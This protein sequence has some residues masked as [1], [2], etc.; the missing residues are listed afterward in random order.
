MID[1][2]RSARQRIYGLLFG[3][4]RASAK[5]YNKKPLGIKIDSERQVTIQEY[6]VDG[7]KRSLLE[8]EEVPAIPVHSLN[9]KTAPRKPTPHIEKLWIGKCGLLSFANLVTVSA[10]F[11]TCIT[12]SQLE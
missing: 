1:L 8:H 5:T 11:E 10:L 2:P 3:V 12:A 4:G 7:T 9:A 6:V